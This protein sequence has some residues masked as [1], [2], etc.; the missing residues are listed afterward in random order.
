MT[1]AELLQHR[2]RLRHKIIDGMKTLI[3]H[4]LVPEGKIKKDA[5]RLRKK[6]LGG[7]LPT[8]GDC[9]L[10]NTL[11][12]RANDASRV[13]SRQEVDNLRTHEDDPREE[14]GW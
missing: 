2:E 3:N 1:P 12:D 10:A 6:M 7:A 4:A 14:P 9:N 11:T 8:L 5:R 13:M